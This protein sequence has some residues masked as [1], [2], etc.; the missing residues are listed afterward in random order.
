MYETHDGGATWTK[1]GQPPNE[2]MGTATVDHGTIMIPAMMPDMNMTGILR[3]TADGKHW[4]LADR[5]V[6][7]MSLNDDPRRTQVV[8][9]SGMGTL[10]VWNN[11]VRRGQRGHFR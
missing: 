7:G 8:Y 3:S 2:P 9:L 10:Y 5:N 6:G 11:A 1:L 4:R